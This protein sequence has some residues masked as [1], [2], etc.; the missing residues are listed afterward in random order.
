MN[1]WLEI[2]KIEEGS[3]ENLQWEIDTTHQTLPELGVG[4]A[5]RHRSRPTGRY[6]NQQL[7]PFAAFVKSMQQLYTKVPGEKISVGEIADEIKKR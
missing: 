6:A 2:R 5:T 3:E 7:P 1:L 4:T